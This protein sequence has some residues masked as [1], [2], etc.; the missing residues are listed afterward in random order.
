MVQPP[1][2]TFPQYAQQL[3]PEINDALDE[4]S[5]FDGDCPEILREAIRY[6]LLSPGKRLRPMLV[7]MA[8]EACGYD[9]RLALPA[10]GAVEMIHCYSLIHDDLPAMD[11]DDLRRGLP[12]C[13]AKFGEANAILAGDALIPRAFELLATK[14]QPPELAAVCCAELARAAG[15]SALVGGQVDDLGAENLDG[16]VETLEAIHRRKTGAMFLV[17]L[18]LGALVSG[19]TSEQ[20]DA[21]TIYGKRLGLAFQVVDDLLDVRSSDEAMGKRTQKDSERGK[22]TFPALLGVEE[23]GM[24]AQ[25]LTEEA[26]N[27]VT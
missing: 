14:I 8:A 12:T 1:A 13:H 20:L 21:L 26:C 6:S 4:Y 11:D 3:L 15:A 27:A 23:S 24:R 9:R 2:S 17:S 5:Q 18:R 25:R 10:A 22:L 7:L 19:A 16:T